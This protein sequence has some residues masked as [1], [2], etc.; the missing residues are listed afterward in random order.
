[1]IR[2]E[3]IEELLSLPVDERRRL[4]RLLQESLLVERVNA[5][6]ASQM[7]TK[8]RRQRRGCYLCPVAIQAVRATL[9]AVRMKFSAPR[10]IS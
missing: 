7:E 9:P 4:L 8:P 6:P 2:R 10:S 1:M 3:H 5:D